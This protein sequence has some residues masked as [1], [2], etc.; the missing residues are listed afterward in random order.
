MLIDYGLSKVIQ[1]QFPDPSFHRL[2]QPFG[3]A[4]PMGLAWTFLGFSKGYNMF[5][6]IA[7]ILAGLLLFRRTLTFGA[8][9]TLMTAM[10]VMAVNYFYDVPVKV[11]S[12]HLVIM[13][14]FLLSRDIK[15][16]ISYLMTN[17][18]VEKLSLIIRPKLKKGLNISL[19][20]LKGLVLFYA[21]GYGFYKS[22]DDRKLYGSKAPKPELYGIY[23]VTNFVVNGDTITNYKSDKL[24]KNIA[25]EH[26]EYVEVLKMN[27]QRVYFR[28]KPDSTG[29]KIKFFTSIRGSEYF[30][31]FY[32]KTNNTLDFRCIFEN[33]TISG[34]TKRLDKEDFRLTGRGFNWINEYPHNY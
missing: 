10:N 28:A 30:D 29:Q 8:V 16:V 34:Q 2:T 14:L 26:H 25:F 12:T 17:K 23:E 19:N 9:I 11:I 13:T 31:F 24:W 3:E 5:M 6:G 33:D 18:P 4:S 20:V 15:Q 1:L 22:L 21:L 7:E 27:E 32:T